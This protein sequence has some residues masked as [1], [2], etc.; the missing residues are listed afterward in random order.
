VKYRDVVR[1]LVQNGFELTRQRGSYRR[2]RST[3]EG[4]TR[5]VTI[6][7]HRENDEVLPETLASIIRQ[8]G[9]PKKLF[10]R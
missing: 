2:Y 8:S 4:R 7:F 1:I 3:V 5:L 6:A 9:L 10:R